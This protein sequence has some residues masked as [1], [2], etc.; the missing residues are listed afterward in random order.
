MKRELEP[1]L[2]TPAAKKLYEV[3]ARIDKPEEMAGFLRDL[4]TL[5]EIEEA[6]RRFLIA[7]RLKEGMGIRKIAKEFGV[8]TTTVVRINYWFHHG[9]GGY[10]LALD[11]L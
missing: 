4:L 8:S 6:S 7:G 1:Q 11:K 2:K 3:L 9:M 10:K 5:E